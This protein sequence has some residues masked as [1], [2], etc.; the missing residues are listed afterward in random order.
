MSVLIKG[1]GEYAKNVEILSFA[2]AE[3]AKTIIPAEGENE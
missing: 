3:N 2:Y 1:I